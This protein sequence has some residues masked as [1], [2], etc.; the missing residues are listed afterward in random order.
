MA[1]FAAVLGLFSTLRS[2]PPR[3]KCTPISTHA[4]GVLE[5]E[6][7]VEIKMRRDK[8]LSL[9]ERLDSTYASLKAASKDLTNT[10]EEKA[11]ASVALADRENFLQPTY[12]QIALLYADLH[13]RTGRMEAKGCA[14]PAVWKETRR[15]FYWALRARLARSEALAQLADSNPEATPELLEKLLDSLVSAA[16]DRSDNRALANALVELDLM[17]TLVRLRTDCLLQ[18]F[19]EVAQQDRKASIDGLVR[20]VDTLSYDERQALHSALQNT[21][22]PGPPSYSN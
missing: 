5:P 9:M 15:F 11:A 20:L 3:W 2:T 13:D 6:G 17:S 19:L 8:I 14:K 10:N 22:S 18:R 1:N 4:P 16:V 21:R 12:K 7:I